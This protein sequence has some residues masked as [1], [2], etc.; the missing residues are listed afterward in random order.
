[1]RS[2]GTI[3]MKCD[4]LIVHRGST[5]RHGFEVA[6]LIVLAI[7][8][9]YLSQH[10]RVNAII[11]RAIAAKYASMFMRLPVSRWGREPA[12]NLR[13]QRPGQSERARLY[14][15]A[16]HTE[17]GWLHTRRLLRVV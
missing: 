12:Y 7:F 10:C 11:P 4:K 13:F 16:P 2:I 1:M 6:K 14:T 3:R 5:C 9:S 15:K 17:Y 8:K